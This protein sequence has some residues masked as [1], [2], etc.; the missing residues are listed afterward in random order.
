[1]NTAEDG[2]TVPTAPTSQLANYKAAP[3]VEGLIDRSDPN[4][5]TQMLL[6]WKPSAWAQYYL[7]QTSAD[8]ETW[9]SFGRSDTASFTAKALYGADTYVRVAAVNTARGPW[10]TVQYGDSA[11][12]MWTDDS[13]LMWDADDSTPMWG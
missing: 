5:V 4:D 3:S 7:I 11:D 2:Q 10:V 8:G 6:S 9:T 1:M 13:A 12:Y